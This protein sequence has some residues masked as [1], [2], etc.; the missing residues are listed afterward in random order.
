MRY[1]YLG[2]PPGATDF[3]SNATCFAF[4]LMLSVVV[5]TLA[6]VSEPFALPTIIVTIGSAF[7]D[8]NCN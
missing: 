1:S 4:S 6:V 5:T 2:E 3:T 7:E 8:D